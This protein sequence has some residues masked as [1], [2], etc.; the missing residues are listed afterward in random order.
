MS[1]NSVEIKI[2]VDPPKNALPVTTT[3]KVDIHSARSYRQYMAPLH[4]IKLL[5]ACI[6][7]VL[8]LGTLPQQ[9]AA[10]RCVRGRSSAGPI[11]RN[12]T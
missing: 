7:A 8:A 1:P 10:Q 11:T 12:R 9:G 3:I 5:F 2:R 6:V 4:L